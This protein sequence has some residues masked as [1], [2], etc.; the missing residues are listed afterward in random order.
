MLVHDRRGIAEYLAEKREHL[1]DYTRI[2]RGGGVVVEVDGRLH[3]RL[4]RRLRFTGAA[5]ATSPSRLAFCANACHW[6]YCST[7]LPDD[8]AKSSSSASASANGSR[9]TARN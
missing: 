5:C 7:Y 2:A 9:C 6:R 1:L 4:R 8:R 3:H